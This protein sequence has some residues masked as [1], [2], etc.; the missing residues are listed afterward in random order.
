MQA[1][2]RGVFI[3]PP[4]GALP[5][6]DR[7]PQG[8][9]FSPNPGLAWRVSLSK[10]IRPSSKRD[11]MVIVPNDFFCFDWPEPES[12]VAAEMAVNVHGNV[13]HLENIENKVW[14]PLVAN[15][16]VWKPLLAHVDVKVWPAS[17]TQWQTAW[18]A[19]VA[20]RN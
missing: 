1:T 11:N 13:G 16:Y 4:G 20:F 5:G 8:K 7:L 14:K 18:N 17:V 19:W 3:P 15:V 6:G 9:L 2:V 10:M 12:V